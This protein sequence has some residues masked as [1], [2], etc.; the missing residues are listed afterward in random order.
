M[1]LLSADRSCGNVA[2]TTSLLSGFIRLSKMTQNNGQY[3]GTSSFQ[4]V[5][6]WPCYVLMAATFTVKQTYHI[7]SSVT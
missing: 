2:A 6:V 4:E 1:Y 7:P 5:T 3:V